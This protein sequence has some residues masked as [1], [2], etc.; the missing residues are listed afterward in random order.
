MV[1]HVVLYVEQ[2]FFI[3]M[4]KLGPRGVKELAQVHSNKR[5]QQMGSTPHP[6]LSVLTPR[7]VKDEQRKEKGAELRQKSWGKEK[8]TKCEQHRG[9]GSRWRWRERVLMGRGGELE[10]W[11]EDGG[12]R[13]AG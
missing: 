5:R 4:G 9:G 7:E 13:E 6:S 2:P 11:G 8:R 10:G 1:H 3:Q 12:K